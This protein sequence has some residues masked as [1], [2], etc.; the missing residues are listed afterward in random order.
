MTR[1]AVIIH[2]PRSGRR[3]GRHHA[4][5]E[6]VHAPERRGVHAEARATAAPGDAT[7]LS[8]EAVAAGVEAIAV[9]GG[10]STVNEAMQPL[11]GGTT[12]LAAWPGERSKDRLARQR[13]RLEPVHMASVGEG[14]AGRA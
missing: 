8:R 4:V 10:D 9:H 11:V 2:N 7:R 14:A 5:S 3:R 1:S 12:P 13:A 6:M